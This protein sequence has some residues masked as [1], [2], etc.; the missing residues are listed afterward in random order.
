M[1]K[2]IIPHRCIRTI[3]Y[4]DVTPLDFHTFV[5][6]NLLELEN[7]K[8]RQT[9]LP[10]RGED[11]K[12]NL[13]FPFWKHFKEFGRITVVCQVDQIRRG[14]SPW[15]DSPRRLPFYSRGENLSVIELFPVVPR[16]EDTLLSERLII[17]K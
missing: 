2:T 4:E 5:R 9:S 11:K 12:I 1:R 17:D 13:F 14:K 16:Q 15:E 3:R 10:S 8:G 7:F 6:G